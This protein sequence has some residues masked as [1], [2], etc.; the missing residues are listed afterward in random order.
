MIRLYTI[1]HGNHPIHKFIALLNDNSIQLLVDVRSMPY[2]RYNPQYNRENL[3]HTLATANP[4]IDYFYAGT[5]LG[6][7]PQDPGCYKSGELPPKKRI[8]YMK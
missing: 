6:G 5:S 4:R 8:I 7:R 3:E 2:S 1:G